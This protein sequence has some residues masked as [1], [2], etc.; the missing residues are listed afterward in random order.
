[1]SDAS[2][3]NHQPG[4]LRGEEPAV[5]RLMYASLSTVS[6]SVFEEIDKIR[7]RSMQ[8]NALDKISVA[9][10]YQ[11]GWFA[12]WMEG[13]AEGVQAVLAR[14]SADPRH[15]SLHVLHQSS[16]PRR[17]AEPWSMAIVQTREESAEFANRVMTLHQEYLSK[18]QGEPA[19]IWRRLSTPLTNPGASRQAL[20]D[21]F[22]R[23]M[24]CSALGTDSFN[25]VRWLGKTFSTEV[26]HRRFVGSRPETM[27]VG[28]DY[29][30]LETGQTVRR[31]IAMA[32][33]GLQIGLTQ[34]FLSDYSHVIV[35][36]S[37]LRERDHSLME[38]LLKACEHLAHRPVI[39][40]LGPPDADHKT[41]QELASR[42]GLI[43]L[44]CD[45]AGDTN[46]ESLWAAAEMALDQSTGMDSVWPPS[47]NPA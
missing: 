28:T 45:I 38:R 26:V 32:R 42:A 47:I 41:L 9:L 21:H 20:S 19:A 10:L 4:A 40:G 23:V 35:L 11:S 5:A 30:D 43:Y 15:Q 12:Q 18:R 27:D 2:I 39:V 34:A 17:L 24:V 6:H 1:M 7:L 46:P 44:D 8:R 29:V 13:P 37:G 14:V 3:Q 16:G 36:L 33:H 31:I 22:Q 25:L